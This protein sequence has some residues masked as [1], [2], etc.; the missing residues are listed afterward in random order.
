MTGGSALLTELF[1]NHVPWRSQS[2][3][4]QLPSRPARRT[5]I[6]RRVMPSPEKLARPAIP[7]FPPRIFT[8]YK[9]GIATDANAD[10][11][12]AP[13]RRNGVCYEAE[14]EPAETMKSP[15]S[16]WVARKPT[17]ANKLP[18][19]PARWFERPRRQAWRRWDAKPIRKAFPDPR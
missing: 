14:A 8:G 19:P 11:H 12:R 16:L 15:A 9:K 1:S 13:S 5:A 7:N 6:S 4:P 17:M 10:R 2:L 3:W 18:N